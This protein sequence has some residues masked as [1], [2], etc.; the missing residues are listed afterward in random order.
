MNKTK[1]DDEDTKTFQERL[2]V[3][4]VAFNNF[5]TFRKKITNAYTNLINQCIDLL[6]RDWHNYQPAIHLKYLSIY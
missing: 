2:T 6:D 5:F 4:V 3:C 1:F